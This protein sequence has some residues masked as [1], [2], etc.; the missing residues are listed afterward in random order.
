MGLP[1]EVRQACDLAA[2]V[3][4]GA[5]AE[6]LAYAMRIRADLTQAELARRMGT[7]QSSVARIEGGGSLPTIEML[8]RLSRA[9]GVPVHLGAPGIAD[10]DIG[11]A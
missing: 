8:A 10:V 2:A 11:A 3:L 1:A 4:P 7:T 5:L 6:L 9:T